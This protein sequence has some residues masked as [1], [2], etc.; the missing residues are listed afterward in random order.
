[1]RLYHEL[2]E[3]CTAFLPQLKPYYETLEEYYKRGNASNSVPT[4]FNNVYP[5]T[6]LV[7]GM[8]YA[9]DTTKFGVVPDATESAD[10]FDKTPITSRRIQQEWHDSNTDIV[11]GQTLLEALKC[12]TALVK[13]IVVGK[14]ILP[15]TVHPIMFGVLREDVPFLDRQ[16]AFVHKYHI[17]LS[18]LQTMLENHPKRDA[19]L[20][21]IVASRM[22]S[23]RNDTGLDRILV[24]SVTPNIVGQAIGPWNAASQDFTAPR[25]AVDEPKV[26]MYELYAWDDRLEDYRV[27][28]IADPTLVI[29][30]RTC[31]D[32]L[33]KGEH[34]FVQVCPN[35]TTDSWRGESEVA[36]L[37]PLQD[38]LSERMWDIRKMMRRQANPP[39]VGYGL[40]G[41]IDELEF[42]TTDPGAFTNADQ[43]FNIKELSPQI[44]ADLFNDV[45]RIMQMFEYT[46]GLT[47]ALQG[48]GQP[49][50]RSG[51]QF[52]EMAR[53]GS[54]RIR[55]RALIIEDSIEKLATLMFKLLRKFSDD[56]LIDTNG[57][58]FLLKQ[59][60]ATCNVKVDAHSSS[61]AFMEDL[62]ELGFALRKAGSIDDE[63]LI[64]F[65]NAPNAEALKVALRKRHKEQ[66]IAAAKQHAEDLKITAITGKPP[67]MDSPRPH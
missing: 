60:P 40:I 41:P 5:H 45:D 36:K 15:Y 28:T 55:K 32:V 43:N 21:E 67:K 24:S 44:P 64:D 62:K 65:V 23:E 66:A 38:M 53:F 35:P 50:V 51:G 16:Q 17:G 52:A 12:N 11:F 48:R 63:A 8:L 56:Q 31:G 37:C 22:D 9:Q 6:D 39:K 30:E 13:L 25:P 29:Y 14:S 4:I 46:S 47:P 18:A 61:P 57:Q 34:P 58:S 54:V 27:I 19:L 7:S 1:M 2:I 26:L 10:I 3:K 33:I 42:A 20:G 59:V 49:G